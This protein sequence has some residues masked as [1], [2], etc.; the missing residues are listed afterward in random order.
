M[1]LRL[2]AAQDRRALHRQPLL[3]LVGSARAFASDFPCQPCQERRFPGIASEAGLA[4][5]SQKTRKLVRSMVTG[6]AE[7]L[8]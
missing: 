1:R 8:S 5:D 4:Q 2:H 3:S 6:T 7:F